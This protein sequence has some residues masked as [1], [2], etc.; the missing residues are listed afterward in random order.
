MNE[1]KVVVFPKR[2][3]AR[4]PKTDSDFVN[5]ICRARRKLAR[6]IE[7]AQQAGLKVET[8]D[9]NVWRDPQIRREF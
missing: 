2:R 5:E 4:G 1:T 8:Q 7:A 3:T 9:F 6:A